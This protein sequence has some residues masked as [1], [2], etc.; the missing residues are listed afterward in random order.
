MGMTLEAISRSAELVIRRMILPPGAATAWHTD[1]C[2]RFTVVVRG[3]LLRIEYRDG[4][5]LDCDI[6]SGTAEWDEPNDR[7]HRAVNVGSE[8][9]EEVV[10][11][12]LPHSLRGAASDP[13]P[14]APP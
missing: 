2:R 5:R 6:A 4:E 11:F 1:P 7:V 10:T 14:E 13:Q 3:S 9:Y 8:I 12:H